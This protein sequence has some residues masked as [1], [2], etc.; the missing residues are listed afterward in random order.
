MIINFLA[1]TIFAYGQT[2]SGKTYTMNGITENAADDIFSYIKEVWLIT[3]SYICFKS[4]K[5]VKYKDSYVDNMSTSFLRVL[6]ACLLILIFLTQHDDL[7]FV[8]KFSALEIY[9]E[10]ASDLLNPESGPLRIM[11]DPEVKLFVF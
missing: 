8:L 2:C 4:R 11:D 7:V 5:R 3:L 9:N 6:S 1:A 10:V